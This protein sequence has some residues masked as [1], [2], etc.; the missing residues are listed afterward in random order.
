M[1]SHY[2]LCVTT[3]S[4]TIA[5]SVPVPVAVSIAA[6]R[7]RLGQLDTGVICPDSCDPVSSHAVHQWRKV[8]QKTATGRPDAAGSAVDER[9]S[10]LLTAVDQCDRG[11]VLAIAQIEAQLQAI[12]Y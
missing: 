9:V 12:E 6:V 8:I 3:V 10:G 7:Q 11:I 2:R 4:V 1:R 5:V